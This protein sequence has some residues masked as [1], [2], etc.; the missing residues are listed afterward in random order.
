MNKG[1][2]KKLISFSLFFISLTSWSQTIKGVITDETKNPLPGV[3]VY[4]INTSIGTT[5]DLDGKYQ[6]DI[7]AGKVMGDSI[8]IVYSF[9]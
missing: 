2:L 6:F 4:V 7:P 9:I 1:L 8:T 5:S 3:S